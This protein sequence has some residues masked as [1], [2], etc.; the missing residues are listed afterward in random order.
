MKCIFHKLFQLLLEI[1]ISVIKTLS[2]IADILLLRSMY[3]HKDFI[4][5]II[6]GRALHSIACKLFKIALINISY[7]DRIYQNWCR[8]EGL[9]FV[10][11]HH[12]QDSHMHYSIWYQDNPKTNSPKNEMGQLTQIKIG[13]LTQLF[14][15]THPNIFV[16][17]IWQSSPYFLFFE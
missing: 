4:S 1:T 2:K 6:Y 8:F 7:N 16:H 12:K 14:W 15:T 3:S 13:Q 5:R 10:S 11:K 17:I 9:N